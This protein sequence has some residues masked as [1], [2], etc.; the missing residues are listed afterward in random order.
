MTQGKPAFAPPV[1]PS[2]TLTLSSLLTAR[3]GYDVSFF[4]V[5]I[6]LL[7]NIIFGIIIDTFGQLREESSLKNSLMNSHC[8]ICGLAK[9]LFDDRAT[10][11]AISGKVGGLNFSDHIDHEHNM[12]D[13]M[14][15]MIYLQEKDPNEYDGIE[16]STFFCL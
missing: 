14:F 2:F 8:F 13:Y 9:D 7:L 1:A 16:R 4:I 11:D 15:Y 5:I 10:R 6:I 12:W 3:I